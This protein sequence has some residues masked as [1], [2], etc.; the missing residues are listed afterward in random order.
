MW[1]IFFGIRS[2]SLYQMAKIRLKYKSCLLSPR[3]CLLSPRYYWS[4]L[5]KRRYSTGNH[6]IYSFYGSKSGVTRNGVT[7]GGKRH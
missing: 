7:Y 1:W 5:D 4:E 2:K 6:Y 3:S